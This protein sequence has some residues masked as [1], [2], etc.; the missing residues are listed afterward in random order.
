MVKCVDCGFLGLLDERGG[1]PIIEASVVYRETGFPPTYTMLASTTSYTHRAV[2]FAQAVNMFNRD[3]QRDIFNFLR[4][5]Q[6]CPSFTTWQQGFTPKE[7]REML[8][9]ERLTKWQADREDADRDWRAAQDKK[10]DERQSALLWQL[11]GVAGL[12]TII[13]AG[14][15]A[16]IAA[17]L[18]R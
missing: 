8:D 13:G 3:V 4:T 10:R 18:A 2:C 9:R 11:A 17:L 7:H 5:E 14:A 15:G 12:F 1:E 16:V 6:D